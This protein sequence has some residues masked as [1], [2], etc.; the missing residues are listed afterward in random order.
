MDPCASHHRQITHEIAL[1]LVQGREI[2]KPVAA[3][4]IVAHA[5]ENFAN[6]IEFVAVRAGGALHGRVECPLQQHDRLFP[7]GFVQ[8]EG[9]V[10]QQM[11]DAVRWRLNQLQCLVPTVLGTQK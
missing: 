5:S 11:L 8:V 6:Q 7:L 1:G 4:G 3:S 9:D 2:R 10:F